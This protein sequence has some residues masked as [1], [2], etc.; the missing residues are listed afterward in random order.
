MSLYSIC[1]DHAASVRVTLTQS[2]QL[3][4]IAFHRFETSRSIAH[5]GRC[6]PDLNTIP[7]SSCERICTRHRLVTDSGRLIASKVPAT[8]HDLRCLSQ[9]CRLTSAV[10][11]PGAVQSCLLSSSFTEAVSSSSRSMLEQEGTA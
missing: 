7:S 2:A 3:S 1:S 5:S 4:T 9:A 6:R 10:I 8:T 11:P